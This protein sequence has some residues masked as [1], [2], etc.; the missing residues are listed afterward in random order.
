MKPDAESYL[1]AIDVTYVSA[2]YI[3]VQIRRSSYCGGAYPNNGV[4]DPLTIDLSTGAAVDWKAIFKPGFLPTDNNTVPSALADMYRARYAKS[5]GAADPDCKSAVA[6]GDLSEF[7]IR[8]D[9]RKG[10][11]VEP[12]FPHA[13][14]A[15]GDEFAFTPPQI[16]RYVAD[17]HFLDD[18][19]R[20]VGPG[21]Y[22]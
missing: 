1:V 9:A 10:L 14:Q 3:S 17:Q 22:Q 4:A 2:R 16:A 8:L 19:K 15:C 7:H 12:D 18:L 11:M 20:N 5:G 21:P 13:I 6:E